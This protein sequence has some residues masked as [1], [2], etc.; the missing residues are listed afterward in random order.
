MTAPAR[1]SP[2]PGKPLPQPPSTD[3]SDPVVMRR[4]QAVANRKNNAERRRLPLFAAEAPVVTAEDVIAR[5]EVH[6]AEWARARRQMAESEQARIR[7][8]RRE[9][10]ALC[11]S[12]EEFLRLLR[13]MIGHFGCLRSKSN[14]W[15][16]LREKLRRRACPLTEHEDVV[17]AWLTAWERGP[18]THHELHRACGDS[19]MGESELLAAL[20]GLQERELIANDVGRA[21]TVSGAPF[22]MTWRMP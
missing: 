20:G 6:R 11:A 12:D 16:L 5:R 13:R 18:V 14:R 1:L 19:L 2:P 10:R 15:H 22:C 9:C 3:R 8:Y 17:L 7:G 4:A 21:C